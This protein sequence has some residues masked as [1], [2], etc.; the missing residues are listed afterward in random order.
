MV[1]SDPRVVTLGLYVMPFQG[2]KDFY[3]IPV[4]RQFS[5]DVLQLSAYAFS[6][7]PL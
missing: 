3:F 6:E 4:Y 2:N 1:I 7:T 5:V